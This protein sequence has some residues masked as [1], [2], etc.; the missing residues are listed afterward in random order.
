[1]HFSL[2]LEIC[3]VVYAVFLRPGEKDML[4]DEYKPDGNGG[5]VCK[6]EKKWHS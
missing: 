5:W 3:S 6:G 2:T 4:R 1:M